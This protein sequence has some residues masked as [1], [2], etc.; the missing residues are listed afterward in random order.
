MKK[1]KKYVWWFS[2][3]VNVNHW[4]FLIDIVHILHIYLSMY[5]SRKIC[6]LYFHYVISPVCLYVFYLMTIIVSACFSLFYSLSELFCKQLF[7]SII[8]CWIWTNSFLQRGMNEA[9]SSN[10]IGE[11]AEKRGTNLREFFWLLLKNIE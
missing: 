2:P 9:L 3:P 11:P 7:N 10:D 6:L 1:L 8:Y 5:L 4:C